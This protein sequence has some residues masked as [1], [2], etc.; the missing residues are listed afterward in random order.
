[1]AKKKEID[2]QIQILKE[3]I[4]ENKIIIGA[5]NV[6]KSIKAKKLDK[7][8]LASNCPQKNKESILHYAKLIDLPVVELGLDNE[9]LGVFCKKNFFVSVIGAIKE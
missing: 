3:R 5:E 2:E 4:K 7:I 8:F 6:F 9:E 1:M